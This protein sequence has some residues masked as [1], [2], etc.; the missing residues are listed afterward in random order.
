MKTVLCYGDSLT[1]GHDPAGNGRHAHGDRWPVVLQNG[2]GDGVDVIAEGLGGRTTAYDDHG[3]AADRNG[4][5][6]LPTLLDTHTPVDLVIFMLGTNDLKPWTGGSAFAAARGLKRLIEIVR[7]HPWPF[8]HPVP[9]IL[10][11]SPP[12]IVETADDSSMG[13][14]PGIVEQSQM[15]STFYS[16]IADASGCGFFDAASVARASPLD[17]V[18]LD[19][20]NT[21]AIGRGIE[22]IVRMMLGL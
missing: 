14:L 18:H 17:G 8:D 21:R 13:Y 20:A 3:A 10:V 12:H 19:A 7:H 5:R 22:P 6:F 16:E 9:E 2:L 1:F 4:V 11:L 15:L